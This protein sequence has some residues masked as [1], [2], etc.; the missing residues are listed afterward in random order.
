MLP[1]LKAVNNVLSDI[2]KKGI[3]DGL[4]PKIFK[5]VL[6]LKLKSEI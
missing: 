1:I 6:F 3:S 4:I 2:I 5:N